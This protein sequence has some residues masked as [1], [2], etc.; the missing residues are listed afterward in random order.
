MAAMVRALGRVAAEQGVAE[1]GWRILANNGSHARQD[2]QHL[3][4]HVL[5]GRDL[6][7]ILAKR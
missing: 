1:S 3:H 2:V 4:V 7:P 6:G 5:G